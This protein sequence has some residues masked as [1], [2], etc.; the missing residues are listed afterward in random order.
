[1]NISTSD[2]GAGIFGNVIAQTFGSNATVDVTGNGVNVDTGVRSQVRGGSG[3]AFVT[4]NANNGSA[5]LAGFNAALIQSP[6]VG[7]NAVFNISGR[8]VTLSGTT[9]ASGGNAELRVQA[10]G[11]D[12]SGLS[13]RVNGL[14]EVTGNGSGLTKLEVF[15]NGGAVQI[16]GELR[17]GNIGTGNAD[18]R[19]VAANGLQ[20]NGDALA[21]VGNGG[22]A[23]IVLNAGAGDFS[24]AFSEILAFD[25]FQGT[26]GEVIGPSCWQQASA[27]FDSGASVSGL[28][29]PSFAKGSG[30]A[31][32]EISGA[33]VNLETPF[34]WDPSLGEFLANGV[35][36]AL[37]GKN[38][39]VLITSTVG[40]INVGTSTNGAPLIGAEIGSASLFG[41]AG[42]QF[43][44]ARGINVYQAP[45]PV[46][47]T[48]N[49]RY[50]T[51]LASADSGNE[52]VVLL[53]TSN[54]LGNVQ[55]NG[56]KTL[57]AAHA[58]GSNI[59][60][61]HNAY[62]NISAGFPGATTDLSGNT[63][64]IQ[65]RV[66]AIASGLGSF[67]SASVDVNNWRGN[68][69]VSGELHAIGDDAGVYLYND[70]LGCSL[71]IPGFV[72]ANSLADTFGNAR[73]YLI[74]DG[75]RLNGGGVEATLSS[76]ASGEARIDIRASGPFLGNGGFTMSGGA[77]IAV[78][79]NGNYGGDST[80]TTSG[81]LV[82]PTANIG[83]GS[84]RI[85]I[86]G[87]FVNISDGI[88]LLTSTDFSGSAT[89]T[90]PVLGGAIVA[91]ASQATINITADAAAT[92]GTPSG[93]A[94]LGCATN[95]C[96]W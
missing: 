89:F 44:S 71:T 68:T 1:V 84:G 73:I 39:T 56:E 62:V 48:L 61:N 94:P 8:D 47:E 24:G 10:N 46:I 43:D 70:C 74:G 63:L 81:A 72:E 64:N 54:A 78:S 38:A 60:L 20:M 5:N 6:A 40:D 50:Y 52:A 29:L 11:A 90:N 21:A 12:A 35:I 17:V 15:G 31:S 30:S 80:S 75:V 45:T 27:G 26:C 34:T 57:I 69:L 9:I 58:T 41:T 2:S 51:L 67:A 92:F 19:V 85:T 23:K 96:T 18:L 13:A 59:S 87:N 77:L 33:N 42:I 32:V 66:E 53:R 88:A 93:A 28:L 76:T 22:T 65:G 82:M 83:S 14:V 55:I 25:A 79:D 86:D 3:N 7:G 37:A 49:A 36:G 16:D 91:D 4:V 95:R